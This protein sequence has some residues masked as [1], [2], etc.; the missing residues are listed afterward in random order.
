LQG[1]SPAI[2]NGEWEGFNVTH[3]ISVVKEGEERAFFVS[4]DSDGNNRL[5]E[6]TPESRHDISLDNLTNPLTTLNVSSISSSSTTATVTTAV[7]HGYNIGD[8]VDI[9]GTLQQEFEGCRQVATTPTA[10]TFTFETT[11]NGG[12]PATTDSQI[13][14]S[15]GGTI[16]NKNKIVQEIEYRRM[17]FGDASLAKRIESFNIWASEIQD[18]KCTIYYRKDEDEQWNKWDDWEF[19]NKVEDDSTATPHVWKELRDGQKPEII[20]FTTENLDG[21]ISGF[22]FQVKLRIEG[23]MKIDKAVAYAQVLPNQ[24]IYAQ[25]ETRPSPAVEEENEIT[26][27]ELFYEIPTFDAPLEDYTDESSVAYEDELANVYEG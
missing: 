19:V 4:K 26:P 7:A 21:S 10:T 1:Q 15:T 24:E 20:P 27:I 3:S 11:D 18:A 9:T 23:H 16:L 8:Y 2:Y 13:T 5:W 6:Y 14:V 17:F 22:S 25:E 12:N